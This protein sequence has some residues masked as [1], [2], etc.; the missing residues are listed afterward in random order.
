MSTYLG[1]CYGIVN[2]GKIKL[3]NSTY[4]FALIRIAT[5]FAVMQVFKFCF[6]VR[7]FGVQGTIARNSLT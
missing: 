7:N 2:V 5:I 6:V 4:S 3:L 1:F